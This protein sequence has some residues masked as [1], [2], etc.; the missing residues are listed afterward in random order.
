MLNNVKH[1][2]CPNKPACP[3]FRRYNYYICTVF[4]MVLDLRLKIKTSKAVGMTALLVFMCF[5][6][7]WFAI[8]G[9]MLILQSKSFRKGMNDF[10]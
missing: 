3:V 1:G 5:H 7:A 10:L 8:S 4:F 2:Y 9:I 6:G